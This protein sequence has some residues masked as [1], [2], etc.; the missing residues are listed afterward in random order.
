MNKQALT[1]IEIEALAPSTLTTPDERRE[2]ASQGRGDSPSKPETRRR[3]ALHWFIDTLA[4]AGA[5]MAG[6]HVGAWL[7][8]PDASDE[9]TS[10]RTGRSGSSE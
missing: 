9:Q 6:V 8:Q 3:A 1:T 2:A 7:D 4:L 5:A 10:C